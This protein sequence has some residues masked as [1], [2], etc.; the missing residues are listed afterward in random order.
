MMSMQAQPRRNRHDGAKGV[1]RA[2][3]LVS[4]FNPIGRRLAGAG[5]MGPNALL[6]VRGRTSG[7]SRT[8]PV[9]FV[10]VGGRRWIIATFGDV[11]WA[12]NLRAAGE[13][14]ITIKRRAQPVHAVELSPEEGARFFREVLTPYVT[15]LPVGRLILAMLGATEILSDPE[16]A[17]RRRPVFELKS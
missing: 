4:L 11:N 10:E 8:T 2:P 17:A 7:L 6:T 14:T 5:L 1:A 15:R 13:A 3:R 12:R 16:G 9:A